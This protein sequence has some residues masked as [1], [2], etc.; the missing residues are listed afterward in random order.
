MKNN[1]VLVG[2][3]VVLSVVL[4]VWLIRPGDKV[5]ETIIGSASS[6]S[7]VDGCMDVNGVTKCY[8]ARDVRTSSSTICS[9]K[10]PTSTSTLLTA[11]L[12]TRT[13]SSTALIYE[14][15]RST[16]P[17][18]TTT[19]IG[20]AFVGA[21]QVTIVAS[22]TASATNVFAPNTYL[23]VKY[24]GNDCVDGGACNTLVGK[25]KA[26]FLVN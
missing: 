13:G 10:S 21:G 12:N 24:G 6:P 25:C 18:A 8:R 26:E 4:S 3:A 11:S 22:S 23:N 19:R 14:F 2:V 16:L 20:S 17:D 1:L 5:V 7:V 9:M 15:G